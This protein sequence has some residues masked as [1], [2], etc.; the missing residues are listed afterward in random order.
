MNAPGAGGDF[1]STGRNAGLQ[2]DSRSDDFDRGNNFDQT[3]TGGQNFDNFQGDQ[4]S[5]SGG[6]GSGHGNDTWDDNNGQSGG[7]KA[8]FGDRMKGSNYPAVCNS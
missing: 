4:Y 5:S 8:S 7:G 1:G 6:V 2:R 3:N